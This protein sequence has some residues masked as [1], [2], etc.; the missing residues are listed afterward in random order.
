[1]KCL[2]NTYDNQQHYPITKLLVIQSGKD[3]FSF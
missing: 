3:G 1:M 2:L